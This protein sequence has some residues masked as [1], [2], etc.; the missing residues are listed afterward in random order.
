MPQRLIL[1][2]DFTY[3]NQ[4]FLESVMVANKIP[5]QSKHSAFPRKLVLP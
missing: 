3:N 1:M 4:F 2:I 5:C